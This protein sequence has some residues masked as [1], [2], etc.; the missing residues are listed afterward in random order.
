[1][2]AAWAIGAGGAGNAIGEGGAGGAGGAGGWANAT[3]VAANRQ[4]I[5][6]IIRESI[7]SY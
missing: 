5:G 7:M 6:L 2:G 4:Q 3:I 1:M